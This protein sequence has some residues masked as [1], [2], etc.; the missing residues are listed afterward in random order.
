MVLLWLSLLSPSV[1][2]SELP[3][4]EAF[5]RVLR[6]NPELLDYPYQLRMADAAKLQAD[7][8]PNPTLGAEVE[9]LLGTGENRGLQGL[10]ATLS[11]SQL[12]ELGGKRDHRVAVADA[13][14]QRL[15]AEYGYRKLEILAQTTARYYQVLALQQQQELKQRQRQRLETA[16]QLAQQRLDLGAAPAGE[17]LRVQLQQRRLQA[18]LAEVAGKLEQARH[19]LS[20]MWAAPANFERVTG[21]FVELV[22]PS[23]A[24]LDAAANA[25][26]E[27]LRLLDSERVLAARFNLL[28]A[29]ATA[30]ITVGAGLR[31]NAGSDDAGIVLQASI[32]WQRENPQVGN[33][34]ANKAQRKL[35]QQQQRSIRE[36]LRAEVRVLRAQAATHQATLQEFNNRLLPLAEQLLKTT[37]NGYTQGIYSL[38][39]L[40]DAQQELAQIE[41]EI[42]QRRAAIYHTLLQLER[43]TGQ[44]FVEVP[45]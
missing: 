43:L 23:L 32:P 6:S 37:Q 18:E 36:L 31:Y 3:L 9:N 45:L 27:L 39:Q 14:A 41:R 44:A 42:V 24:R 21:A 28:Q 17:L 29:S 8:V 38:L 7:L 19:Q 34:A 12:I 25:A 16:L 22:L 33:L 40:L 35:V 20:A 11:L 13:E 2:A 10:Q 1:F 4:R 15:T 26:P 30:D 5:D